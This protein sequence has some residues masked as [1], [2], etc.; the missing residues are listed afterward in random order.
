MQTWVSF[1]KEL[2]RNLCRRFARS[3]FKEMI[4]F[5]F[6][7]GRNFTVIFSCNVNRKRDSYRSASR[8]VLVYSS[9]IFMM[10][11]RIEYTRLSRTEKFVEILREGCLLQDLIGR[12]IDYDCRKRSNIENECRN[13]SIR[14][15]IVNINKFMM[16]QT[17]TNCQ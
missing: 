15:A 5:R 9:R 13:V 17:C 14:I 1:I 6:P 3:Y 4:I 11:S 10:N 16:T 8:V 12:V 2:T 7:C